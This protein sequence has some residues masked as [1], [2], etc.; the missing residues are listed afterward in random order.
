MPT[1][2][3]DPVLEAASWLVESGDQ[4]ASQTP[5]ECRRPIARG[6]RERY[7]LTLRDA[8]AACRLAEQIRALRAG[9]TTR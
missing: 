7:G 6:L 8:A 1:E 5:A 4:T 3:R 2:P 9:R